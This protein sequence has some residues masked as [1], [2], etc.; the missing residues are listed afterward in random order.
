MLGH[1]CP[2]LGGDQHILAAPGGAPGGPPLLRS[3]PPGQGAALAGSYRAIT[4][5]MASAVGGCPAAARHYVET[6]IVLGMP[7]LRRPRGVRGDDDL[8]QPEAV[9]RGTA[10]LQDAQLDRPPAGLAG[11]P[12]TWA[13]LK[14]RTARAS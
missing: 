12:A 5:P 7:V 1:R 3:S 11:Q 2:P 13:W 6:L 8:G 9:G 4:V 14:S 10:V